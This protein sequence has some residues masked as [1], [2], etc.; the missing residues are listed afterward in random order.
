M[1]A[2][3]E[4]SWKFGSTEE[5]KGMFGPAGG[6]GVLLQAGSLRYVAMGCGCWGSGVGN[7]RLMGLACGWPCL[8]SGDQSCVCSG[9]VFGYS[10]VFADG[11]L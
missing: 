7:A 5:K 2:P 3:Q 1:P 4:T 9:D 8:Y 6:C 10:G 11:C